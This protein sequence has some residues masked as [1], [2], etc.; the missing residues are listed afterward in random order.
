MEKLLEFV[1]EHTIANGA[2]IFLAAGAV[3][4][5]LGP[6]LINV[7]AN[8]YVRIFV[9]AL[10]GVAGGLA[11]Y[12]KFD[13]PDRSMVLMEGL[14]LGVGMLVFALVFIGMIV[15]IKGPHSRKKHNRRNERPM[16]NNSAFERD[17]VP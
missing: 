15:L 4:L 11:A 3:A 9:Y 16:E 13:I 7:G 8:K 2:P 10:G 14:S 1:V 6:F 12:A 17:L 5:L